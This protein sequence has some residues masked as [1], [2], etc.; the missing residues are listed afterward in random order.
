MA[1]DSLKPQVSTIL[2]DKNQSV[3]RRLEEVCSLLQSSIDYYDWVGFYFADHNSKTLHLEA[4]SGAPTD[5][6][7]YHSVWQRNLRTGSS[8]QRKFCR[9]QRARST[10]LYLLWH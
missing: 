9:S 3:L 5:H 7:T 10:K 1:F 4:F 2:S 6:V 8:F